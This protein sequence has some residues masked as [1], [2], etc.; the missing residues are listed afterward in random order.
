[1]YIST[2]AHTWTHM[3]TSKT[4]E[5]RNIKIYMK[6]CGVSNKSSKKI[7]VTKLLSYFCLVLFCEDKTITT[8]TKP[9]LTVS[10]WTALV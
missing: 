3:G 5:R 8:N 10:I 6:I 7:S 1:M 9:S 2:H 4:S